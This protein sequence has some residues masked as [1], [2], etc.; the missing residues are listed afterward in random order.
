[1]KQLDDDSEPSQNIYYRMK[2][3]SVS[4]PQLRGK[5]HPS[6]RWYEGELRSKHLYNDIR[7][8]TL[9]LIIVSQY[10]AWPVP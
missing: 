1:M 5:S 10:L 6:D 7:S 4:L 8:I 3:H 2:L 9:F